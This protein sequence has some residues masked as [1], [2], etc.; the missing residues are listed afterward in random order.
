M[1]KRP[2]THRTARGVRGRKRRSARTS[3]SF[4]VS[5][6]C[7]RL[8]ESLRSGGGGG[9]SNDTSSSAAFSTAVPCPRHWRE[10]RAVWAR[11]ACATARGR[12]TSL[13]RDTSLNQPPALQPLPHATPCRLRHPGTHARGCTCNAAPLQIIPARAGPAAP[14]AAEGG[15]VRSRAPRRPA[16]QVTAR[17]RPSARRAKPAPW[18]R[19]FGA[20]H[21]TLAFSE[22]PGAWTQPRAAQGPSSVAARTPCNARGQPGGAALLLRAAPRRTPAARAS[23]RHHWRCWRGC[24][25][26]RARAGP[27]AAHVREGRQKFARRGLLL[28][29]HLCRRAWP[30][31]A[32]AR[33]PRT[34]PGSPRGAGRA[35]PSPRVEEK[36]RR[37]AEWS[38][39]HQTTRQAAENAKSHGNRLRRGAALP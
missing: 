3:T 18:P 37:R 36:A 19:P 34:P 27:R 5:G 21:H 25:H 38:L 15:R 10:S 4:N 11:E 20:A 17:E 39:R 33:A 14:S 35:P 1:S 22:P 8:T 13:L 31:R 30:L 29:A 32:R 7:S 28:E 26:A 9:N 16:P 23:P 12:R 24:R 6:S 2:H